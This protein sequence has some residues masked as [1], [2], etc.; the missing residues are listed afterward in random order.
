MAG[1]NT[2]HT[3]AIWQI[4][5]RLRDSDDLAAALEGCLEII[6]KAMNCEAGSV[7]LMSNKTERLSV[8]SYVGSVDI[9]GISV[10]KNQGIVGAV[11]QSGESVIVVDASNDERFTKVVD[12]ETGFVTKSMICVPL[13]NEYETIGCIELIN[14]CSGESYT[15]EDLSL[16]EQMASLA[17]VAIEEKG[18]TFDLEE[19]KRVIISLRGVTKS[20]L[21]GGEETTVLK[22]ID[23]DIYENEFIVVLGESGCGKS[24]MM[25][26]IGGMDSLTEG[27]LTVEGKD[28]SHPTSAELT[29]FRRNY[30]GF[31]FQSYNLMPNLTARENVQFIA[32]ISP[33]PGD[34]DDALEKVGLT[35]RAGNYPAQ[36][37]GG[38]QQRVSIAR[39]LAKNPKVIF[40]DEP[41][42][43]LDYR[44]S[45]EVLQ[46]IEEIIKTQDTTVMM[47]TH[48][49][50]I[51]KMADRVIRLSDGRISSIR[52][53]LHPVSAKELSW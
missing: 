28:F 33:N 19:G 10:E 51:A 35:K 16:L 25:N 47:I 6:T 18:F 2:Q 12:E 40:A 4:T 15:L 13:K 27:T 52:R 30:V 22:G 5:E 20:Y 53:N 34:V 46:V 8:V 42:A 31:V 3:K 1:V 11:T 9:S 44:T 45:I 39:A 43:A 7:W 29:N 50:E 41:T 38:Q 26:I 48:N 37:S 36:M 49:P 23:L 17:A 24:T 21:S 32:E 14:K